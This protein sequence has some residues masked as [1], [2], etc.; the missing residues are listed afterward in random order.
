MN[1]QTPKLELVAYRS[2]KGLYYAN[3]KW[4]YSK[5]RESIYNVDTVN[6]KPLTKSEHRND[7][8]FLE[9]ED[10][11]TSI[12]KRVHGGYGAASWVLRDDST[13]IE[14]VIPKVVT[15]EDADEIKDSDGDFYFG[16]GSKYYS[17]RGLYKRVREEL[18]YVFVDVEFEVDYKGTIE[19]SLIENNYKD[20]TIKLI[21]KNY[22]KE[23]TIEAKLS[24]I[25]HYYELEELLTPDLVIHN[26]PCYIDSDT[27]FAIVRNHIKENINPKYARVTSDYNFCFTVKK[28]VQINP[29]VHKTEIKKSNGR[30]Y[31]KPQFKS[32]TI[33]AKEVEIFEMCPSK[34]YQNYT[35]IAGFKGENLADLVENIKLYLDHL[36]DVINAPVHECEHCG[37]LG[38]TIEKV[39]DMNERE[40][41]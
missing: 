30:S 13:F 14:G 2:E 31:A 27:T 35:P 33:E 25:T 26:R 32:Q 16:S 5:A 6:G 11:I 37:G 19:H 39:E 8:Y 3:T 22:W 1:P 17:Y 20:A 36:M 40:G 21:E 38:C 41:K 4:G 12:K 18:P 23:V 10:T 7:W 29:Y 34:K 15:P 24:A 9:G 28:R